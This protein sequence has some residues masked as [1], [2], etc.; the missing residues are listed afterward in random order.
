MVFLGK[1][2]VPAVPSDHTAHWV[3]K[4]GAGKKWG[5]P[6]L[7]FVAMGCAG[8]V[9]GF[10]RVF[11][12]KFYLINALDGTNIEDNGASSWNFS[13]KYISVL[14]PALD[15]GWF[16]RWRHG[17][18]RERKIPA[19][20]IREGAWENQVPQSILDRALSVRHSEVSNPEIIRRVL[21]QEGV[22]NQS[23]ISSGW[24]SR[25]RR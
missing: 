7:E 1:K 6:G 11:P 8:R 22:P 17:N 19:M 10:R 12:G 3:L 15:R 16:A 18:T 14:E 13:V 9:Y 2:L 20:F 21:L 4:D 23:S 24:R 25:S 5:P